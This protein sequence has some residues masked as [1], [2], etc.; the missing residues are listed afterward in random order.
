[1]TY[2]YY[3]VTI[4]KNCTQILHFCSFMEYQSF[5]KVN[6]QGQFVRSY[7]F[8]ALIS[9]VLFLASFLTANET[10]QILLLF[11]LNGLIM[12]SITG[13][14]HWCTILLKKDISLIVNISSYLYLVDLL[15]VENLTCAILQIPLTPLFIGVFIVLTLKLMYD[16]TALTRSAV[17]RRNIMTILIY[18]TTVSILDF[19]ITPKYF[20]I[21]IPPFITVFKLLLAFAPF[22]F[23]IQVYNF[24]VENYRV[25]IEKTEAVNI[26]LMNAM[27]FVISGEMFTSIL[28]DMKN[29]VHVISHSVEMIKSKVAATVGKKHLTYLDKNLEEISH[30]ASVFINYVK[31]DGVEVEDIP[32][33]K[34]LDNAIQFVKMSKNVSKNISFTKKNFEKCQSEMVAVSEYR[35]FSVFLNI[36]NNAIQ[37]LNESKRENKKITVACSK[38]G[39]T[40][41]IAITDNGP[42]ISRENLD[43]VFDKFSTKTDGNGLGLH[44]ASNYISND[45]GG[46]ISVE[47][48]ENTATTFL[49]SLPVAESVPLP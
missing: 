23:I 18:F 39:G 24:A 15:T 43:K 30:I 4:N 3:I 2:L 47:S 21:T 26:K 33:T 19:L 48:K 41:T 45:L 36:L 13:M 37:S 20:G 11:S 49:I 34:I 29:M 38:K 44:L 14:G 28:H 25:Q 17:I 9:I 12:F 6:I 32:I 40:V 10:R 16:Q 27:R 35:L 42:G 1:M 46:S 8:M 7:I 31:M 22:Y 5:L